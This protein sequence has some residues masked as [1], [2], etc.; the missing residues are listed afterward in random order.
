MNRP[1][2]RDL[3]FWA[4]GRRKRFVI[5]GQSMFPTLKPGDQVLVDIKTHLRRSLK[6]SEII[7][8]RQPNGELLWMATT[9]LLSEIIES[10]GFCQCRVAC[11]TAKGTL[12]RLTLL[13]KAKINIFFV[14]TCLY[15]ADLRPIC[16]TFQYRQR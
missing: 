7:L 5:E 8:F 2:W 10:L 12:V 3:F 13:L 11:L 1:R 4:V 15:S 16:K 14:R 9:T 6:P